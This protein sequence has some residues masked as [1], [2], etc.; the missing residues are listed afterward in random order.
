M[1]RENFYLWLKEEV[2]L[3]L[4]EGIVTDEQALKILAKSKVTISA[5][6]EEA[7]GSKIISYITGLGAI[8]IGIGV[9]AFFAS[10]WEELPRMV[11][12][13]A[14]YA[15]LFASYY[16]GFS[17]SFVKRTYPLVGMALLVLGSI[18]FC[19]AIFLL[20]QIYNINAHYPNGLLLWGAC[21]LPLAYIL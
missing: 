21:I 20:A 2:G 14:I 13:I 8:L 6:E 10:N 17:L 19:S 16:F 9:I 7:R 4:K 5:K 15:A 1:N 12:L 11:K 3:W 18:L